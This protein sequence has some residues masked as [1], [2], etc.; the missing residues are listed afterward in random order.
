MLNITYSTFK[1][2]EIYSELKVLN[3]PE[4]DNDLK[5]YL[6]RR[7][8]FPINKIIKWRIRTMDTC[9]KLALLISHSKNKPPFRTTI[10]VLPECNTNGYLWVQSACMVNDT[11][12]YRN[13]FT[14]LNIALL[15]SHYIYRAI[16]LWLKEDFI[17]FS[18]QSSNYP[19]E[20][21]ILD[22]LTEFWPI[23]RQSRWTHHCSCIYLCTTTMLL[24]L[25]SHFRSENSSKRPLRYLCVCTEFMDE[26]SYCVYNK[27][28]SIIKFTR[29]AHKA[30]LW[31]FTFRV[32]FLFCSLTLKISI[33]F[34]KKVF[35]ANKCVTLIL[36]LVYLLNVCQSAQHFVLVLHLLGNKAHLKW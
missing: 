4:D 1:M 33:Y 13:W 2:T 6:S 11:L 18:S 14:K 20:I 26:S 31:H 32:L 25:Q 8:I 30:F 36:L 16:S 17:R 15:H 23:S 19:V 22:Q 9:N 21:E 34:Y 5:L 12:C 28:T 7:T 27:Y 29:L 24:L 10:L 3:E 35:T